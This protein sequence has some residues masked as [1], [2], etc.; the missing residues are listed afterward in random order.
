MGEQ[1]DNNV[2]KINKD[3]IRGRKENTVT[4]RGRKGKER[5][6]ERERDGGRERERERE[7]ERTSCIQITCLFANTI[8]NDFFNSSS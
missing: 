1:E 4:G 7:R 3:V 8:N 5:R 2:T 6:R